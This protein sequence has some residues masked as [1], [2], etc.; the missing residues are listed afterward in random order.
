MASSDCWLAFNQKS[1]PL[2]KSSTGPSTLHLIV[3]DPPSH[4]ECYRCGAV[5]RAFGESVL[6]PP[7]PPSLLRRL[8]LFAGLLLHAHPLHAP[9]ILVRFPTLQPHQ[10]GSAC[11]RIQR[12]LALPSP[13]WFPASSQSIH[14]RS[15][16]RV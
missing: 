6:K 3:G 14:P 10:L 13:L 16:E 15:E 9:A 2:E 1:S 8:L 7:P 5:L 11:A 4:P 12:R